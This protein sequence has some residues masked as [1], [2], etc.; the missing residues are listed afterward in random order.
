M[1]DPMPHH[2]SSLCYISVWHQPMYAGLIYL[3]VGSG[4]MND[5]FEKQTP[6]CY[7]KVYIAHY[8]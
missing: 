4:V 3:Q 8:K 1:V 5:S 2:G 7:E 6:K